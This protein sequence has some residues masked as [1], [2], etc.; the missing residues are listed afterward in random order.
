MLVYEKEDDY[1][2]RSFSS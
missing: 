2:T 1:V